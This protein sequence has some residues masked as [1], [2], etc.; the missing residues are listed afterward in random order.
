MTVRACLGCKLGHDTLQPC[1]VARRLHASG[2]LP[3]PGDMVSPAPTLMV[4]IQLP[5]T[6]SVAKQVT[7]NAGKQAAFKLQQI[8][9][10]L[11]R[12]E[13]WAHPD[14]H[15]AIKAFAKQAADNRS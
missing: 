5:V 8:A 13:L 14:D 3:Q 12:L 4:K 9:K 11:V 10:G 7:G 6:K 15:A 2:R 1:A